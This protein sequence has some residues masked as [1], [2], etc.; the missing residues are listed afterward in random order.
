MEDEKNKILLHALEK[1]KIEGFYKTTMDELASEQRI[2]KKTIYKH[3]PTK[4]KLVYDAVFLFINTHK[5]HIEK[6]F[7]SKVNAVVKLFNFTEYLAQRLSQISEK[8][9]RDVQ[10]HH[11]EL[12]EEIDKFR[13]KMISQR[14]SKVFDQGK[15]EGYVQK[16]PS[17]FLTIYFLTCIRGI[18]NP[19][20]VINSKY[21]MQEVLE[22][23]I[24]LLLSGIM[25]EKGRKIF[26][27]LKDGAN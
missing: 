16:Y 25:T 27:K 17:E 6:I 26:K 15:K 8:W 9:F 10:I 4:E 5:V 19:E 7:E 2:S 23:T 22:F 11:R 3:F 24:T 21:S 1:F 13:T 18:I 12:W 14:M 20:F